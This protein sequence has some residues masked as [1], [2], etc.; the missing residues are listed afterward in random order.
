MTYLCPSVPLGW[1]LS[2]L[3]FMLAGGAWAQ[4]NWG[5]IVRSNSNVGMLELTPIV[6]LFRPQAK[7]AGTAGVGRVKSI[8]LPAVGSPRHSAMG[9]PRE[10]TLAP[11]TPQMFP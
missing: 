11:L 3:L 8:G 6:P 1:A 4:G 2:I 7:G 5:Q 9:S 10:C